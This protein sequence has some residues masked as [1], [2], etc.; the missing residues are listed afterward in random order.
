MWQFDA[1][2]KIC[3]GVGVRHRLLS[4][5]RP[6]GSRVLLITGARSFDALQ[7]VSALLTEWQVAGCVIFHE[8]VTGEPS[9]DWVD[10]CVSQYATSA[11]DVVLA[12]GGGSAIDA[13]K[14]VA[15]LLPVQHSV[16][17][18]LEG[19]GVR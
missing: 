6:F 11:I 18:Y 12:I 1:M 7:D 16:I 10:A 13:A 19:L 15:G 3:F 14:A 4:L 17:N 2:P 5:M 8:R 9:P